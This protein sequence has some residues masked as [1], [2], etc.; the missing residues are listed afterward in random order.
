MKSVAVRFAHKNNHSTTD[1]LAL[2]SNELTGS[3]PPSITGLGDLCT[4]LDMTLM[5]AYV[6]LFSQSLA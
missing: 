1:A 6:S 4:F 2:H 5:Y 3:I